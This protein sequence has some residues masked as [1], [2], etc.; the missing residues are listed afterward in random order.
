MTVKQRYDEL[1]NRYAESQD[2]ALLLTDWALATAQW[3]TTS[4]G[5]KK[6]GVS[7][8]WRAFLDAC[9]KDLGPYWSSRYL[10]EREHCRGCGERYKVDN[11]S[12]CTNCFDGYCYR[13]VGR[14]PRHPNGNGACACGGELVG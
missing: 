11:L 4:S 2:R 8:A 9:T 6:D 12:I 13:C 5:A 1:A 7:D 3:W 10:D 14:N